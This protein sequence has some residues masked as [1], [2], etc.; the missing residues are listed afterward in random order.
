MAPE[1][2]NVIEVN[3]TNFSQEV[4]GQS[5]QR[6]VLMDFWAPWCGPCKMLSPVLEKLAVESGGAFVLAKINTDENPALAA[7]FNVSSI[8]AVKLVMD[9]QI[10]GEFTGAQPESAIRK[11]LSQYLDAVKE[12]ERNDTRLEEAQA[13]IAAGNHDGATKTL[14]LLLEE[15]PDNAE[16]ARLLAE[17]CFKHEAAQDPP[18]ASGAAADYRLGC[19]LAA[20]GKHADALAVFLKMVEADKGWNDEAARKAMLKV[21]D[22]AGSRS[23]L[24]EEF[25]SKLAQVLYR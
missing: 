20:E 19:A 6:P 11:F 2:P 10:A 5:C 8:P 15:E 25:R 18:A 4:A 23:P 3:E 16:A 9:G 24:A 12:E 22:L 17:V 14:K 1:N 7:E 13:L 21:F